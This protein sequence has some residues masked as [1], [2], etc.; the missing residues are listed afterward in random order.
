MTSLLCYYSLLERGPLLHAPSPRPPSF[1]SFRLET[2]VTPKLQ[3]AAAGATPVLARDAQSDHQPGFE[4]PPPVHS[5][6]PGDSKPGAMPG[7]GV[8]GAGPG[9]G[10]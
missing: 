8:D 4:R 7:P 2:A 6:L 10:P 1:L 9:S 5:V 3:G